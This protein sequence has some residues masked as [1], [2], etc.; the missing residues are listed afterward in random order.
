MLIPLDRIKNLYL[1]I[2]KNANESDQYGC[3][4]YIFVSNETDSLCALRILT[5]ILKQDE[6]Q[7]VSI[8]VFSNPHLKK[9]IEKLK[10]Y[11]NTIRSL[12]FLN[13]G[14]YSDLSTYWFYKSENILSYLIDNHRPYN[15]LNI[16]DPDNKIVIVNDGCRSFQECPTVEDWQIYLQLQQQDDA[17]DDSD[18]EDSSDMEQ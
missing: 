3:T 4:T 6:I 5:T 1:Q 16:N 15:H 17:D 13:C 8:P 10:Q 11:E 18:D 2:I 9:E 7:F 14:G 12:V